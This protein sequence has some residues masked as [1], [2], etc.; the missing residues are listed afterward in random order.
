MARAEFDDPLLDAYPACGS[1]PD[2][3]RIFSGFSGRFSTFFRREVGPTGSVVTIGQGELGSVW[4]QETHIRGAAS[5]RSLGK[6]NF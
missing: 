5:S 4:R 3:S 2:R 1:E 6:E